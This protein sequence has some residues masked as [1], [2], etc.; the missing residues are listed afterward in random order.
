[1]NSRVL[2]AVVNAAKRL[3]AGVMEELARAIIRTGSSEFGGSVLGMVPD[4]GFRRVVEDIVLAWRAE[5]DT[6]AGEVAAM[7]SAASSA[8]DLAERRGRVEVV[9]TGPAEPD[10][11][12][13][14]TEA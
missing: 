3:P 4:A 7:V 12:T 13:R 10:A 9:I 8:W 11:P 14:S 1:M 2:D 5:P 6:T